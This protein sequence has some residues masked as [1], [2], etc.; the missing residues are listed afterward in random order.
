MRV[1]LLQDVKG[2]GRKNE[3]VEA[4]DGYARNFLLPKKL[5]VLYQGS[6]VAVKTQIDADAKALLEGARV[7]V[8]KL[9]NEKLVF[10]VKTGDKEE[11]FGGVNAGM[12]ER[13]LKEMGFGAAKVE[14]VHT[15]KELG[16]HK[17]GVSFGH[18]IKGEALVV[19]EKE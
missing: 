12:V 19:L 3:V 18:G 15:L 13:R 17:A 10:V 4:K 2:V 6:A 1:L 16:E 9:K 5:A 8:D 14:L 11:V 7:S